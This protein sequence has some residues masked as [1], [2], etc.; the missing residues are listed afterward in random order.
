MHLVNRTYLSATSERAWREGA[1]SVS[2]SGSWLGMAGMGR[3]LAWPEGSL[4]RGPFTGWRCPAAV[5]GPLLLSGHWSCVIYVV[6][7]CQEMPVP[8]AINR[9]GRVSFCMLDGVCC[10][11]YMLRWAGMLD[12]VFER[13]CCGGWARS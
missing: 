13:R 2:V 5:N 7:G 12:G 6:R 11:G 9:L 8:G 1:V 10:A 3:A 4:L